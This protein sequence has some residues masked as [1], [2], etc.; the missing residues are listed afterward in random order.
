MSSYRTLS[1]TFSDNAVGTTIWSDTAPSGGWLLSGTI[2]SQSA[3]PKLFA[4]VG[5]VVDV[6]PSS[7]SYN[8]ATDFYLPAGHSLLNNLTTKIYYKGD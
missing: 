7:Y 4:K 6:P 3:Y 2:V 5:L 8:T 1:Q